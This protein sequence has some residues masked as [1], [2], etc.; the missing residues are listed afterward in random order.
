MGAAASVRMM[1]KDALDWLYVYM[2]SATYLEDFNAIDKDHDGG[3]TFGELQKWVVDKAKTQ[4]G[5]WLCFKDHPQIVQIAHKAAGMGIDSKSSA[6]AG[7]VVDV[8]EFRLLLMHLFAI[9]ILLAHF[10]HA[11]DLGSKQLGFDEFKT[12]VFTF[13]HTHAH[14]TVSDEQVQEDFEMLDTNKSD[15]IS[16]MEVCTYCCKFINPSFVSGENAKDIKVPFKS[17]KLLGIDDLSSNDAGLQNQWPATNGGALG[18][19][20]KSSAGA[21]GV[22]AASMEQELE[23][24]DRAMLALAEQAEAAMDVLV[25]GNGAAAVG[26]VGDAASTVTA[27]T[28]TADGAGLTTTEGA[29]ADCVTADTAATV[30]LALTAESTV[31]DA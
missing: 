7:K 4:G 12:A 10:E 14:E 24:A 9:S 3:I 21:F 15:T 16:F 26:S 1:Y 6:H 11:D 20:I 17:T 30:T 13:C 27:A 5:G 2:D 23:A 28:M 19:G 8:A 18:T 22:I 31:N 29:V 25:A